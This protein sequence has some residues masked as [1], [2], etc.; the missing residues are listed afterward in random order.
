[1]PCS[2]VQIDMHLCS[3]SPTAD[4]GESGWITFLQ[5]ARDC[6]WTYNLE[7][8][9]KRVLRVEVVG[10]NIITPVL[11]IVNR[12]YHGTGAVLWLKNARSSLRSNVAQLEGAIA[13]LPLDDV[14]KPEGV[15]AIKNAK[16]EHKKF[17]SR[18]LFSVP[19]TGDPGRQLTFTLKDT[20]GATL[21]LPAKLW[22]RL[23][24]DH[25]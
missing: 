6:E 11:S 21:K 8:D 9:V 3:D 24:V 15:P 19:L 1:M 14:P 12:D 23:T 16:E 18:G 17:D 10:Y 25:A 13:V 2:T 22:L 5:T 7:D 4:L 20:E